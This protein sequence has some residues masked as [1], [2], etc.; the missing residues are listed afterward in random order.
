MRSVVVD[1]LNGG[2]SGVYGDLW[3]KLLQRSINQTDELHRTLQSTPTRTIF[4]ST[5]LGNRLKVAAQLIAAHSS[6]GVDRDVFFIPFDGFDSH[7]E[8]TETLQTRFVEL[9][10]ALE[11]FVAEMKLLGL[12]DNVTI[13]QSSDFG[14]TITGNS[15]GGTD[16]GWGGNYW[17]AGGAVRGQ[18]IVGQY[19]PTFLL[20]NY[21]YNIDR[22]RII[23]TTSWDSIF[24]SIASW[25][26]IDNESD[27]RKVLPNR[28][29]FPDV[30]PASAL[31]L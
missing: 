28:H 10:D 15:G 17:L 21:E 12:W 5:G 25:M 11:D 7:N 9:N 8:V 14:R 20:E 1:Q 18:R 30:F 16:H 3:S 6:R 22:G 13:V 31:F 26:G 4:P 19:P 23:P 29:Q 2:A 27:L 24:N